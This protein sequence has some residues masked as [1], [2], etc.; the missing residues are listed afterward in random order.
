MF[1][2]GELSKGTLEYG[3]NY[4]TGTRP[5][6]Q[7]TIANYIGSMRPMLE[8]QEL[9]NTSVFAADLHALTDQDPR[10]VMEAREELVVAYM[11]LG[12]EPEITTIYMQS[13]IQAE[14]LAL[15]AILD[16][17][18]TLR[19]IA[20]IP[21]LKDKASDPDSAT[22]AL[23]GYPLLMAADIMLQRPVAVPTGP[24]Q[25]A[26]LEVTR[27][28]IESLNR[29]SISDTQLPMT[30][31]RIESPISILDLTDETRKMSKTSPKGAIYLTDT[32][33]IV[34]AKMKRAKTG[35]AGE[36]TPAIQNL[37][38]IARSLAPSD[39]EA[40]RQVETT[41][42]EHL[43]GQ[44]VAGKLKASVGNTIVDFLDNYS[45]S[46]A[47]V[48]ADMEFVKDVVGAG[49]ARARVTAQ[50]TLDAVYDMQGFRPY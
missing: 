25:A 48:T 46:K 1:K 23:A 36:D 20:R 22:M 41:Y 2:S 35:F 16:R 42:A 45:D 39:S 17:Y 18:M 9:G 10:T 27:N 47:R 29:S 43:D 7:L 19:Q 50:E 6:A 44:A 21:T 34:H 31:S 26:H 8:A 4:L 3:A 40:L 28:L 37:V 13:A 30:E 11:A 32:P 12:L 5:S 33:E 38:R 15:R 14:T 49:N 24:D